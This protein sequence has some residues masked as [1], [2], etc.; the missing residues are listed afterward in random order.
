MVYCSSEN[1]TDS[2]CSN[3]VRNVAQWNITDT[4]VFE[5]FRISKNFL[6]KQ[7]TC[8]GYKPNG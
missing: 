7:P 3:C 5:E 8:L 1:K 4:T 2:M 6:T